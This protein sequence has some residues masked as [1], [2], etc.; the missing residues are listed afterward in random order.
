MPMRDQ[1]SSTTGGATMHVRTTAYTICDR[2]LE[3]LNV[4]IDIAAITH[5]LYEQ[6]Y[7][8]SRAFVFRFAYH[9]NICRRL[10][11]GLYD[12]YKHCSNEHT[13]QC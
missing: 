1:R 3:V 11:V 12:E 4:T 5:D 13:K 9:S 10:G 6:S 2:R 8:T 7:T